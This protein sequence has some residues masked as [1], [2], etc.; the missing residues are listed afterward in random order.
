MKN[1]DLFEA[2]GNADD[3]YLQESEKEQI[4]P[5]YKTDS[6]FKTLAAVAAFVLIFGAMAFLPRLIF[7]SIKPSGP[8]VSQTDT[9]TES[10]SP[11]SEDTEEQ[12]HEDVPPPVDVINAYGE[13]TKAAN[14]FRLTQY[15]IAIDSSSTVTVD[16][17]PYYLVTEWE[18]Y[19]AF[20]AYLNSLFSEEVTNGLMAS[21]NIFKEHEGKLYLSPADGGSNICIG[22]ETLEYNV[23]NES[24][25]ELIAHVDITDHADR[26]DPSPTGKVIGTVDVLFPY[27]K[28]D[29]KWVFTDFPDIDLVNTEGFIGKALETK[30]ELYNYYEI[31]GMTL[32]LPRAYEGKC[33]V[34]MNSPEA[35]EQK[36]PPS[37]AVTYDDNM[38]FEVHYNI[39]DYDSKYDEYSGY[40]FTLYRIVRYTAGEYERN[41]LGSVVSRR[42]VLGFDGKYYY[43][44]Q[45]PADAFPNPDSDYY[46][47]ANSC[48]TAARLLF[49]KYNGLEAVSPADFYAKTYTYESEHKYYRYYPYGTDN[50]EKS[51][52]YYTIVLSQPADSGADGIWCVERWYTSPG[53]DGVG[54]INPE[55]PDSGNLSAKEFYENLQRKVSNG[56]TAVP[57]KYLDPLSAAINFVWDTIGHDFADA[58]YFVEVDGLPEGQFTY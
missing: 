56:Q 10:E 49:G 51:G 36:T 40:F 55:F 41:V 25:I 37:D 19:D 28:I 58:S 1:L 26:T 35:L 6:I 7:G 31:G 50:E 44:M 33:S 29:G 22:N 24:R 53:T 45:Y 34:L 21:V 38:L 46:T 42:E 17:M 39:P 8:A 18:S 5:T 16:G 57:M 11:E 2:I 52:S 4:D 3:K 13:A 20:I 12:T 9:Q 48:E 54:F 15:G 27:E 43:V 47:V 32:V 14:L 30:P 23:I